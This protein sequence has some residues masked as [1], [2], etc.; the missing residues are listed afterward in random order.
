MC[1]AG[2]R[3]SFARMRHG[4]RSPPILACPALV[5]RSSSYW[6]WVTRSHMTL[7]F[8][9][10]RFSSPQ[11]LESRS[12]WLTGRQRRPTT[13]HNFARLPVY[14]RQRKSLLPYHCFTT[15]RKTD[16]QETDR[17]LPALPRPTVIHADSVSSSIAPAAASSLFLV[18][19]HLARRRG[20]AFKISPSSKASRSDRT[21]M[22]LVIKFAGA[23]LDLI[24]RSRTWLRKSPP[25]PSRPRNPQSSMAAAEFSR[26]TLQSAPRSI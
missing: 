2:L 16:A 7:G 26:A 25:S 17:R 1:H 13:D 11:H 9:A 23:L 21:A 18:L 22:K 14:A 10:N 3:H 4:H 12:S 20:Q 5:R 24:R 19:D 6:M 8:S 15:N